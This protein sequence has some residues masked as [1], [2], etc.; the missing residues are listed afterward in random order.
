ML[1]MGLRAFHGKFLP[2]YQLL[3]LHLKHAAIGASVA[4][5]GS[6]VLTRLWQQWSDL[7]SFIP[8]SI[9][10]QRCTLFSHILYKLLNSLPINSFSFK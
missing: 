6:G 9:H 1:Q 7:P 5:A 3:G 10:S 8:S 4:A 2:P